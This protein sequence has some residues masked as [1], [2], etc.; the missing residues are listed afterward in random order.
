[1]DYDAVIFGAGLAGSAA[2]TLLSRKGWK[3]LILD[4]ASAPKPKVCGEFL[5]PAVWPF[6]EELEITKEIESLGGKKIETV[7]LFNSSHRIQ[8]KL[9]AY[10]CSLSRKTL[11]PFL[12]RV[13]EKSGCH[14]GQVTENQSGS[15]IVIQASGKMHRCHP[16][17]AANDK[18]GFKAHFDG[19]SIGNELQLFFF[20][21]AYFGIVEVEDGIVN[22]CGIVE[23]KTFHNAAMNFDRLLEKFSG[24]NRN[25]RDWLRNAERKTE[26]LSCAP[27]V[28]GKQCS[29]ENGIFHV[30]DA[31]YFI[32]P[33]MGQGMTMA[34]ASASLLASLLGDGVPDQAQRRDI[35]EK[36]QTQLSALY[37]NRLR[38]G[39]ALNR[40][41]FQN[42]SS[43]LLIQLFA[44]M[45]H[46]WDYAVRQTMD[47]HIHRKPVATL[48]CH[49]R[50]L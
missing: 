11:D 45:P 19:P 43:S 8:R 20:Q 5:S 33:F 34:F 7:S 21:G 24:Q 41:A 46:L 38:F 49:S 26:W 6:F 22:L 27:L 35:A 29:S 4:K 25:F 47:F 12:I 23:K 28:H 40:F 17:D 50:M 3:V 16:D 36:Y 18:I 31:A 39:S 9:P 37:K 44:W 1:M 14:F 13:A 32:E 10:G 42:W 15:P 2:G 48:T 30:G